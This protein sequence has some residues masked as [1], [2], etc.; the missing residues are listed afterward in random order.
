MES[1]PR[2]FRFPFGPLAAFVLALGLA[3]FFQGARGLW[4]PDEGRYSNVALQMVD[5]GDYLTP[6]RNDDTLHVTKP[7]VTYWAIA[8]SVNAFGR[9]EWA[10]RLPT[11]LAFALTVG[12]VFSLGRTLVPDRPWLPALVYV[13]C[14]LPFL[15]AG[16]ITTDT[17]LTF[18]ETAAMLAYVRFRFGGGSPRWLDAMW[19]LFGLA[20]MVKGPPGLLPL[21]AIAVW[22]VRQRS[23]ALLTRPLGLTAFVLVGMSWFGWIVHRHPD[24]LGYFVGDEVVGRIASTEHNRNGEWYGGFVVYLPTLLLGTLPWAGVAAWRRWRDETSAPMPPASRFLWLWLGLP[25]LVFFLSRSRLPLYLLPLFVPISLLVAMALARVPMGRGTAALA[26]LWLVFLLTVK[27][28]VS[29]MPSQQDARQLADEIRPLLPATPSEMVFVQTKARYGLR[30]YL[31]SEVESI[32]L[33]DLGE[34]SVAATGPFDDDLRHELAEGEPG[35]YYLVPKSW[36]DEF[37]GRVASRR[38]RL[39]RLGEVRGLG[40]YS[41]E[42]A[43]A[44]GRLE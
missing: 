36:A 43:P 30:F 28:F 27:V 14:P 7:P 32:S 11:A 23:L 41:V 22:E 5:S 37:E 19:A 44:N 42:S 17:L 40:V 38:L 15:A 12:L 33:E 21:L 29:T 8:A 9:S 18:A 31:A 35:V 1:A 16:V 10:L 20:F 6:R 25:L 39:Q 24:L 2:Q 13:S 34:R 4:D 26:G 3:L